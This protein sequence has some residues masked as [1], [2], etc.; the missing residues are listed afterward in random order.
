MGSQWYPVTS[1]ML[2][3]SWVSWVARY[4]LYT[5]QHLA[6]RKLSTSGKH[7]IAGAPPSNRSHTRN[8]SGTVLAV[9]LEPGTARRALLSTDASVPLSHAMS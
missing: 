3:V 9:E 7:R 6:V 5:L 1:Q 2:L 8:L 4:V